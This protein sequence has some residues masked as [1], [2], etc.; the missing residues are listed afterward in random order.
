MEILSQKFLFKGKIT[1]PRKFSPSKILGYTVSFMKFRSPVLAKLLE[2][3]E[4]ENFD[5]LLA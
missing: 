5:G 3:I 2:T 4:R 1:Q